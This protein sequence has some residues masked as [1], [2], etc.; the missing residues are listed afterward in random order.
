M[1]ILPE[2]IN[3]PSYECRGGGFV[4]WI[5]KRTVSL[6]RFLMW[7][8]VNFALWPIIRLVAKRLRLIDFLFV[9]YPGTSEDVTA[10]IPLWLH[11]KIRKILPLSV[12]GILSRGKSGKRG[13]IITLMY[14]PEELTV[15]QLKQFL[16]RIN[17]FANSVGA[18][19]IALAGRLPSIFLES[20]ISLDSPFLRGD[21]GAV[22]TVTE[23]LR[24]VLDAENLSPH[25]TIG[26]LGV[27]FIGGKVVRYLREIGYSSVIGFDQRVKNPHENDH[28]TLTNDFTLL[29]HCQVVVILTAKGSD[30][31]ETITHFREGVIVVDDTHPQ[32]PSYLV[33]E[34]RAK[35]GKVYKSALGL[36]G[37]RF[38]PEIPGYDREWLP[39][40][41]IEA[42][43][44]SNGHAGANQQD[45][46]QISKEIGFR[47]LLITPKGEG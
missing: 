36:E 42:L 44:V 38:L 45:F 24:H 31:A 35:K 4:G 13:L 27:G 17:R 39:G 34:I 28:I 5:E 29:R 21:R 7:C 14:E 1:K 8:T 12:L 9:V 16:G 23:T 19:S 2:T 10:Y 30:I 20:R 15:T 11:W 26:V 40:C 22:F 46:D 47:P 25:S 18:T 33:E 6:G 3:A 41:V 43:V 32:L 37:V